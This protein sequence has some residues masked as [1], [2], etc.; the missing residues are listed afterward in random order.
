[1]GTTALV[2]LTLFVVILS[3]FDRKGKI[4]V[5]NPEGGSR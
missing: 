4:M 2:T 5:K 3:G 1:M